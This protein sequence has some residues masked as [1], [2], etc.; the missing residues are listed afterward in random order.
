MKQILLIQVRNFGG[1]CLAWSLWYLEHRMLNDRIDP[2]K[3]INKT[4]KK[5]MNKNNLK[6]G[7][8][9]RNYANNINKDRYKTLK[10]LVFLKKE[11]QMKD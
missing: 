1:F 2:K 3:L 10:K 5:L 6:F 11:Y 4:I 7:E 9:I 8:F